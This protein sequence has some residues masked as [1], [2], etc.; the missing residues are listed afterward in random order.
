MVANVFVISAGLKPL[1]VLHAVSAIDYYGSSWKELMIVPVDNG[2]AP[3][4]H[5]LES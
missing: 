1:Q 4:R 2:P 5:F 3:V